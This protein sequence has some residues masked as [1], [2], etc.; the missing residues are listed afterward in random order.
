MTKVLSLIKIVEPFPASGVVHDGKD[1]PMTKF[2][3]DAQQPEAL[4]KFGKSAR[5]GG[6]QP[7]EDGLRADR[8]T[9]PVPTDP[10][11]KHDAATKVLQE[12]VTHSDRGADEAID[13]LP[14]RITK[15]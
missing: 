5:N 2:V 6:K 7:D 12:G 14:D 15:K 8:E 4:A 13:K 10:G 3:Q 9:A 11:L 1:I